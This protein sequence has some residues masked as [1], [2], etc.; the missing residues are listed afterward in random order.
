[1]RTMILFPQISSLLAVEVTFPPFLFVLPLAP[2]GVAAAVPSM[3]F[4]P[5][6]VPLFHAP[7]LGRHVAQNAACAAATGIKS[8]MSVLSGSLIN[9]E[10]RR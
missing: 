10:E 1:M 2:F 7:A 5:S 9:E 3:I 6:L 4:P 8:W